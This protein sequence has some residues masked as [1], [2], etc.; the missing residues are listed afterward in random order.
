MI[1][2]L[3]GCLPLIPLFFYLPDGRGMFRTGPEDNGDLE[4]PLVD[5]YEEDGN[6]NSSSE[7]LHSHSI[8]MKKSGSL[9]LDNSY[10]TNY[11][12]L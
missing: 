3:T 11:N 12:A 5:D 6:N 8:R 10:R 1:L 7:N 2:I 4:E 9:N